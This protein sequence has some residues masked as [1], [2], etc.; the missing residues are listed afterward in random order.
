VEGATVT[1]TDPLNRQLSLKT[2]AEGTFRF[3]NVPA[4]KS[5]I[6]ADADGYLRAST[7]INLEPRKDVTADLM[8]NKRPAT[9]NVVITPTEIKLKKEVHFLHGSA[10]ILPDSMALLEEAADVIRSHAE[11]GTIEI[12]G[13][14]DDTGGPDVNLRLSAA[15]ANAVRDVFVQNGVDAARLTSHGYGQDKPLVP[16][17]SEKNRAKNRR[18]QLVIVK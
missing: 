18:V 17:T 13:H 11:L 4:G 10:E 9:P 5:T 7:E 2:D 15:R 8:L 12:Q 1:I 6:V 14:T 16:N 3:G